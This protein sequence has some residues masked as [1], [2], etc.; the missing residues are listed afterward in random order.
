MFSR[1]DILEKFVF[2]C[3]KD[4]FYLHFLATTFFHLASENNFSD[5]LVPAA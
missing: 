1:R 5:L 4:K 3:F 2:L